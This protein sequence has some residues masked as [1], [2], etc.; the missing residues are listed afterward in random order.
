MLDFNP[1]DFR[2]TLSGVWDKYTFAF[3]FP[4]FTR[5]SDIPA[6]VSYILHHDLWHWSAVLAAEDG[7]LLLAARARALST[8]AA[9]TESLTRKGCNI[10]RNSRFTATTVRLAAAGEVDGSVDVL[11]K[12]EKMLVSTSSM[13]DE[14]KQRRHTAIILSWEVVREVV[15]GWW[16]RCLE[17]ERGWSG[18][19]ICVAVSRD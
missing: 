7:L 9:G 15:G 13:E 4:Q 3:T 17:M 2:L 6:F 1:S 19:L 16:L 18:V 5:K 10:W 11:H 12:Q 14:G 8:S